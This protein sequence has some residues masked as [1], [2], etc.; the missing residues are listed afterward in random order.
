MGSSSS[1]SSKSR[2]SNRSKRKTVT[3]KKDNGSSK[4]FK[5]TSTPSIAPTAK[6]KSS[7]PPANH[8]SQKMTASLPP[9]DHPSQKQKAKLVTPVKSKA[10]SKPKSQPVV[11]VS[12]APAP[13]I[14]KVETPK[15]SAAPTPKVTETSPS[16]SYGVLRSNKNAKK[17]GDVDP[18]RIVKSAFEPPLKAPINNL[19]DKLDNQPIK[20]DYFNAKAAESN[21]NA[22]SLI[23]K[24]HPSNKVKA[25]LPP[26]LIAKPGKANEP[27]A[28]SSLLDK[29]KASTDVVEPK[30]AATAKSPVVNKVKSTPAK[31]VKTEKPKQEVNIP[32]LIAKPSKANAPVAKPSLVSK[33]K[34]ATDIVKPKATTNKVKP[35]IAPKVKATPVKEP[36]PTPANN[37]PPLIAKPSE[38]NKPAKKASLFNPAEVVKKATTPAPKPDLPVDKATYDEIATKQKEG[39]LLSKVS[40]TLGAV[41]KDKY[42]NDEMSYNQ[43]YWAARKAG[44]ATQAEMAAEQEKIGMKKAYSG[45]V[46]VTESMKREAAKALEPVGGKDAPFTPDMLTKGIR[47]VDTKKT[48]LFG[49]KEEKTMTYGDGAVITKKTTDPVIG[50]VR[51]GDKKTTT[52]ANGIEQYTETGGDK[53]NVGAK[54]TGP[55]DTPSQIDDR[56]KAETVTQAD[57]SAIDEQISQEKDP[58]KLKELHRRRLALMRS[59]RTQTRFNSLLSDADVKRANLMG[60]L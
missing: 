28:K 33:V 42:R 3:P 18:K 15:V 37:I 6:K 34:A 17:T 47:T 30:P 12:A 46:V 22:T 26:A 44:G 39:S 35:P 8:P 59:M 9:A 48:G 10:K 13:K 38:V 43:A 1:S 32:P 16:S 19:A 11:E 27:V 60:I 21:R 25:S 29:V 24:D 58:V 50:N 51:L 54:V 20:E 40:P 53:N 31:V 7:R 4:Y 52:Y 57:I 14:T 2:R 5:K 56:V 45:D 23:P 55:G 49:E 41:V 36:T